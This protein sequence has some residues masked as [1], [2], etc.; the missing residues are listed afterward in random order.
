MLAALPQRP[1]TPS[2]IAAP[3]RASYYLHIAS[4]IHLHRS[5]AQR[6]DGGDAGDRALHRMVALASPPHI[7]HRVPASR[8][9][10]RAW[11]F[12]SVIGG[13]PIRLRGLRERG[14]IPLETRPS[15]VAS[16]HGRPVQI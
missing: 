11:A 7:D 8:K 10:L 2:F 12:A 5:A 3:Q 14:A 1:A 13:L 15:A 16:L 6:A 9:T 4:A